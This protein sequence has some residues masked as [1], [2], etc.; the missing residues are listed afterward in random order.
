MPTS[1]VHRRYRLP[2]TPT[3]ELA[4]LL[5]P[6]RFMDDAG[7]TPDP[8]QRD[9]LRS[10][11]PRILMLNARQ[12]GK[13][14]VTASLALHHAIFTESALVLLIAK[15]L[16]QSQELFRKVTGLLGRLPYHVSLL[17]ETTL[18]LE[19]ENG[20]RIICLPENEETIRGFS[21]VTLL[22]IDEAAL[23]DDGLYFSVRSI[24]AVSNGRLVCLSTPRGKRGWFYEQWISEHPWKRIKVTAPEC[25]RIEQGFLDEERQAL[26]AA[27]Y[28][29]EY[30]C[31]FAQSS[32]QV[33][34]RGQIDAAFNPNI[35][36]LFPQFRSPT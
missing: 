24:L 16:R 29:Q 28:G 14:T 27:W 10:T 26:G 34:D 21:E 4:L 11:D 18:C 25:T 13:S 3:H 31:E 19:F 23:V 2:I 12:T 6:S 22:V 8:W 35:K 17:R 20:S 32:W 36:P 33:F 15:A 7:F 1:Q 30:L 9:V 5:D